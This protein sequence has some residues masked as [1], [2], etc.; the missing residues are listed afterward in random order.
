MRAGDLSELTGAM[1]AANPFV[2]AGCVDAVNK[3]ISRRASTR[4]AAK[5]IELYPLP[6]VPGAGF[7]NNNFISNGILNNDVDQ[8]DMRVDHNLS[9]GSDHLFARYSFQ[10]TDR[11]EPPLLDDPVA[12]GDFASDILNRGQN[13][14]AGGRASSARTSSTSSAS[15]TT[16][17]ART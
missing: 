6:N 16:R 11:H 12:S 15:A 2:P 5:L 8:F 14:V 1:V 3:I 17:C 13:A 4:S 7:F 10:N 9:A